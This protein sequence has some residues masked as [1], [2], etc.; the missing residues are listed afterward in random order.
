MPRLFYPFDAAAFW[1]RLG[2]TSMLG[3]LA[4]LTGVLVLTINLGVPHKIVGGLTIP[5][6]LLLLIWDIALP[7]FVRQRIEDGLRI[8]EN[9][10]SRTVAGRPESWSWSDVSDFRLHSRLHPMRLFIGRS[11][12][13]RGPRPARRSP[14]A[15]LVNRIMFGGRNI[16]FGNNYL[17][18]SEELADRLN[19]Y[20]DMA[21]GAA[22]RP[23]TGQQPQPPEPAL[24]IARESLDA[25]KLSKAVLILAGTTL[26]SAA[27]LAGIIMWSDRALPESVEEFV[28]SDRIFAIVLPAFL[29]LMQS[30]SQHFW[31]SSPAA[32]L[33][34]A[35]AG[36]LFSS[37]G[38]QRKLWRWDEI[39]DIGVKAAPA[40]KDGESSETVSFTA[41]HDG[42]KPGKPPADGEAGALA[43]A[44][45]DAYDAPPR[46]IARRLETWAEWGRAHAGPVTHDAFVEAT[47]AARPAASA[48]RYERQ[49]A[50]HSGALRTP[51]I[52]IFWLVQL[53]GLA[54][55]LA[56]F[57]LIRDGVYD[58]ALLFA[59]LG[60]VFLLLIGSIVILF[61]AVGGSFNHLEIGPAGLVYRRL[62]WLQ[63]YGWHELAPFELHSARL[64]WSSTQRSIILF[65]APRDDRISRYMR[66]AY[67]I[68]GLQ[69]RVV[70]EDVYDIA[71]SEILAVL[72][73]HRR[74]GGRA[75]RRPAA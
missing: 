19:R 50:R 34:L 4:V 21:T 52:L 20:R 38:L 73:Q 23:A 5:P 30:L 67:R 62:G 65:A 31:Q 25:G 72:E 42:T 46:E 53:G 44:F 55:L 39:A 18:V 54:A 57:L 35:A 43:N 40:G 64:R 48:M 2:I 27:L 13:F 26:A 69:P 22:P 59:G 68:G 8:D 41:A 45:D 70:I 71:A 17:V 3:G 10:L 12:S 9:G 33:I 61:L 37:N 66:W 51:A 16:A 29:I 58:P 47:A 15:A 75:A 14:L 63:R 74:P 11:I 32:N 7:L 36:G 24:F 56:F 6:M 60:V 1:R 49:A 28:D